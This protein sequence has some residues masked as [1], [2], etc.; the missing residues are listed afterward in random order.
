MRLM[1]YK[2][3]NDSK[4]IIMRQ[5]AYAF[6]GSETLAMSNPVGADQ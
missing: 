2:V 5:S 6:V 4:K 3:K 1:L